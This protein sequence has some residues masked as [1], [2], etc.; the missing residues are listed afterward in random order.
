MTAAPVLPDAATVLEAIPAPV[1]VVG[2]GDRFL[3]ANA[4]A[5]LFCRTSVTTLRKLTPSALVGPSHPLL[6]IIA[7]VVRTGRVLSERGLDISSPRI[8]EHR[9]VDVEASPLPG[10]PA[11]VMLLLHDRSGSRIRE[12]QLSRKSAGRSVSGLTR[13]L[14]HEIKNPL[15]GIRGAAQLL[16][17]EVGEDGRALTRLI[18]T[19][20]DRIRDLIDSMES[21]GEGQPVRREPINIH[22]VLDHVRQVAE[23]G[24]AR[25]L[26]LSRVYDPSL[27]LIEGNR[28][29]LIQAFLNLVKN[30]AEA[31]GEGRR[32]G[33]IV[34]GTAYRPG[35][36]LRAQGSEA[37]A[38]LPL[39]VS[40][41][42]NGPGIP[43]ELRGSLFEPFVTTKAKGKGLG[44]ALVAKII[45]GHGG[46]VEVASNPRRT[47]FRVLLPVV[48]PRRTD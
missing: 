24:F 38:S 9:S 7:Q 26:R 23:A 44:L 6:S 5:E 34:L 41:Q 18:V 4:A 19:E 20:T 22:S 46:L 42:D 21:L 13:L 39:I 32:D 3:Y 8:G 45:D 17:P 12:M 30:A 43:E 48:A 27:P 47:E 10:D 36:R 37:R 28:D 1:L 29:Q 11:G 25:G 16:E 33:T 15:S 31:I 35:M 14:A 40:V 2:D